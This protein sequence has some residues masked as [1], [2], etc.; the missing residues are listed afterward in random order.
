MSEHNV[1]ALCLL[2]L[3]AA[4]LLIIL[5][6]FIASP[7]GLVLMAKLFLGLLISCFTYLN[8]PTLHYRRLRGDMNMVFKIATG[9]MDSL[10]SY[11][12]IG[13]HSVTSDKIQ[14]YTE[15]CAL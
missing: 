8:L 15:G 9:F 12:F 3:S 10:V 6:S 5:C 4:L 13:S 1:T 14:T 11:K 7:L 2:D